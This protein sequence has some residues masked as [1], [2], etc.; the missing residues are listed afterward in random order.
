[1]VLVMALES[2]VAAV[3]GRRDTLASLEELVLGVGVIPLLYGVFAI[4]Y[5]VNVSRSR[6][7]APGRT[8]A[9]LL[10]QLLLALTLSPEL[11]Y[12]VALQVGVVLSVRHAVWWMAAQL[13]V[14][15]VVMA[16]VVPDGIDT[17]TAP[18]WFGVGLVMLDATG[19]QCL[20]AA[21]SL[22]AAEAQRRGD[23]LTLVN[24][25]LHETQEQLREHTRR[26]ERQALSRELH[27]GMGHHLAALSINLDLAERQS[28][29]ENQNSSAA[30][31]SIKRARSLAQQALAEGRLIVSALRGPE[32]ITLKDA[33]GTLRST[34][35]PMKVSVD[36]DVGARGLSTEVMH[37]LYRCA[38]EGVTNAL[39][40]SQ[41]HGVHIVVVDRAIG[42]RAGVALTVTDDGVGLC[43]P[44]EGHG[45]NGVRERMEQMGGEMS[46]TEA[47]EKVEG[48]SRGCQLQVW[49]PVGG[50]A[51][52]GAA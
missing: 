45:L 40:H 46:L 7:A 37:A 10:V 49:L 42:G 14:V 1:M 31:D 9:L 32:S 48:R 52:E 29:T 6:Q 34:G 35:L 51:M 36:Y 21:L 12:V 28:Q 26:S 20:A 4:A 39:K 25:A 5:G 30:L 23:A 19:W 3:Y 13:T 15:L 2:T 41:G 17:G 8:V 43:G 27:D 47:R 24:T 16:F 33:L 18:L 38:Q 50:E 44:G 11:L 22:S